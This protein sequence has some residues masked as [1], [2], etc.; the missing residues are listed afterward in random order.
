MAL[1]NKLGLI[2]YPVLSTG[3]IYLLDVNDNK[4][5]RAIVRNA[6]IGNV[7][8][9]QG[10][11]TGQ[12]AWT[13]IRTLGENTNEVFSI[14]T[15]DHLRISCSAFASS[16]SPAK[17]LITLSGFEHDFIVP[18]SG[19]TIDDAAT[20]VTETW[21][22][23][24]IRDEIDILGDKYVRSTR[25]YEISSGTGGTVTL[26]PSTTIILD[27]FGGTVDAIVSEMSAGKPTFTSAKT[28]AGELIAA[29]FDASGN[30]SLTDTPSGYSVALIYRLRQK[31]S[32]YND[33]DSN[34]LGQSF[35]ENPT[36]GTANRLAGYNASGNLNSLDSYT[37]DINTG[38]I[39]QFLTEQPNGNVQYFSINKKD[40]NLEPLQNSAGETWARDSSYI[41]IDPNSSGFNIGTS[42]TAIICNATNIVHHGTSNIGL[43]EFNN[44]NFNLGNGADA[45]DVK[46]VVYAL[47]F[48]Q[49]N[50]DV[51]ISG[52]LQGYG[53][54]FNVDSAA[55]IS[56]SAYTQGFFDFTNIDCSSPNYAS[57]SAGPNIESIQNNC[58]YSAFNVSG[59]INTFTGN[60]GYL[61]VAIN[62]NLGVFNTGSFNGV[63][64]NP[65]ID[66]IGYAAGLNVTMDNVTVYPGVK[67]SVTIQDLFLEAQVADS[68]F[69]SIAVEYVSDVLAG[70]ETASF[71]S[72]N[73]V[74]HIESGVSTA[75]QVKAAID[76]D[77]TV[78]SSVNTTI[79]GVAANAQITQTPTNFAGGISSGRKQAAYLDG[80]VEITGALS[81]S[82]ALSIGK[83]NAYSSE[84]LVDGGGTPSSIHS[85]ITQPTVAANVTIMN[86]DLIGVNTAALITIG[87]N[88][89]VTTTFLGVAAL[90]LPAV[91]TM[92]SGSTVDRV[93]GAVFALSLDSS[94]TG[95]TIN[96][97]ALCR[98]LALPNGVTT[99]NR[100]YGYQMDLPFGDPGTASWG[101]YISPTIN[102]FLAGF[103]KIGGADTVVACAALEVESTVKGFLNARMT[104][105][106]R[107]AISSPQNGLQIYNTST[108]KLQVY[109]AGSWV[110]LH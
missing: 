86:A 42:G 59:A 43:I 25:Y 38:G 110:D 29:S 76:A 81:F 16:V 32:T 24:K 2:D 56:P 20:T 37:I 82:G 75:T 108:D 1:K 55:T 22:S 10:R 72:P 106:Q 4:T 9:V 14:F 13:T 49:V 40:F 77:F 62:P 91:I 23:D 51:N 99:V 21:S 45:I 63:N 48:G 41:D 8:L 52:S 101:V 53:F 83:L 70:N 35:V 58:N 71:F 85:L 15:Y 80:D 47:G 104:T 46:G 89:I 87:N 19:A 30:Y 96:E 3:E 73:I 94:A 92:G 33:L 68:G 5:I 109:A 95:G 74:V 90:A 17:V 61:G 107:D 79:T 78:N 84:P 39:N 57:Y 18:G 67:A 27:D 6:G 100:L 105:A 44:N 60:A 93:A 34:I 69:N 28:A 7:I 50:A 66:S 36:I 31:L 103:L 11:I 98:A 64:I 97:V 88:S 102:N 26:D 12:S 65:T 54:Q